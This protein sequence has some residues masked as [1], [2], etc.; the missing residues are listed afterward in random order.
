MMKYLFLLLSYFSITTASRAVNTL[1]DGIGTPE[2]LRDLVDR[3]TRSTSIQEYSKLVVDVT[4]VSRD[5][6]TEDCFET[7]AAYYNNTAITPTDFLTFL[8]FGVN[9]DPS[10]VD[11]ETYFDALN[12]SSECAALGGDVYEV[13]LNIE[14]NEDFC[15]NKITSWKYCKPPSCDDEF[16]YLFTKNLVLSFF[17]EFLGCSMEIETDIVPSMKCFTAHSSFYNLTEISD[18]AVEQ[19]LLVGA[20]EVLENKYICKSF[21]V[22]SAEINVCELGLMVEEKAFISS[23]CDDYEGDIYPLNINLGFPNYY[24]TYRQ[25]PYCKPALC[26]D[27]DIT[28]YFNYLAKIFS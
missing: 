15:L 8:F 14:C 2:E 19:F 23:V 21:N 10:F 27:S 16:N 7:E 4:R 6:E 12:F 24:G 26:D 28:A 13:D 20:T 18:Y 3:A 5:Q 11:V 17:G 1:F 25:F 22:K 9:A